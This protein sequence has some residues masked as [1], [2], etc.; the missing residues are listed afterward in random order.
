MILAIDFDGTIVQHEYPR[1]GREIPFA[2]HTLKKLRDDGHI[3]IL[4]TYREGREL[5]EAVEW[6]RSRGLE[7]HAVNTSDPMAAP[8]TGP[9][10]INADCYIDD[11]NV[12]GLPD[13]G[14]IYEMITR[15]CS[16]RRYLSD[17]HHSRENTPRRRSLWQRLTGR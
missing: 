11:R 15:R 4:W 12:G 8:G 14:A 13:W 17:L 16:Y 5:D 9:R 10:K 2:V 6:C 1:I 3:L 7:F